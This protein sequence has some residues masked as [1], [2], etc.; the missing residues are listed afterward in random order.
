MTKTLPSRFEYRVTWFG[1]DG[2]P[3][4]YRVCATI[5]EAET[6]AANEAH[7]DDWFI[8]RELKEGAVGGPLEY[9]ARSTSVTRS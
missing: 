9:S 2:N 1:D 7:G 3:D 5:E 6:L 4:T 8:S